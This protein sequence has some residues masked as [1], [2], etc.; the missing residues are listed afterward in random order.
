MVENFDDVPL[1]EVIDIYNEIS[2]MAKSLQ[3]IKNK[4]E[5]E[6]ND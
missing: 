1:C 4:M 2:N 6:S 5:S 3:N